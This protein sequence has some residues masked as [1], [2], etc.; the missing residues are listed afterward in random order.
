[1]HWRYSILSLV[2]VACSLSACTRYGF[3]DRRTATTGQDARPETAPTDGARDIA[4][5]ATPGDLTN[6]G[7]PAVI[8][9]S[10]LAQDWATPNTIRW[11]WQVDGETDKLAGYTLVVGLSA[12][13]VRASQGSA[14]RWDVQQNPELGVF[15]LAGVQG[16]QV[17]TGTITDLL[18]PDTVYFA[19]LHVTDTAG[20]TSSTTVVQGRT[21]RAANNAVVLF[22]DDDTQGYSIPSTLALSSRRPYQ[23][24][25]CYEY[26]SI[27]PNTKPDCWE[28]L[29]RQDIKVALP[30]LDAASFAQA[31][32]E[33]AVG[34]NGKHSYWS[35]VWLT[36][37]S[38]QND[39]FSYEGFTIR[40]NDGYRLYQFPLR[41]LKSKSGSLN[42][43]DAADG[44]S[45]FNVGGLWT[46]GATVRLDELRIRW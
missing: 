39:F 8:A 22:S 4:D 40:C 1:M 45:E 25:F 15:Q 32:F 31:Y 42:A 43:S 36:F 28:N 37:G 21:A 23:G 20:G 27:C 3:G 14:K 41:V 46:A 34:C 44:V 19:Q 38:L 16:N 17:I 30:A 24:K 26:V 11:S 2:V 13:D 6:D 29:R 12:Q 9:I 18:A 35:S 5:I 33:V 10:T 7:P